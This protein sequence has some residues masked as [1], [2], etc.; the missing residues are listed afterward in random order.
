[1][2]VFDQ[3]AP[4]NLTD[5]VFRE[6]TIVGSMSGYGLYD[7]T[8][9]IMTDPQFKGGALITGRISLD[10]LVEKGYRGL[11]YEKE[12]NVKTLVSPR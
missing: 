7:E 3:P 9:R 11:L 5:L 10:D 2:G 6:K 4:L 12:R 1:M 8:I